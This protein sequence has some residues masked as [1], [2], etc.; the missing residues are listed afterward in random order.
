MNCL[1][2]GTAIVQPAT[3]RRRTTCSDRCRK[4]LER[5]RPGLT[6]GDLARRLE[7]E[8][9]QVDAILEPL[10]E[11]G[12]VRCVGPGR[13]TLPDQLAR[14]A[15]GPDPERT[16]PLDDHDLPMPRPGPAA[17]RPLEAVAA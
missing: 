4:A 17:R 12:L 5:G 7:V 9:R 6:R 10:V 8:P 1:H 14:F 11:H 3:G 2:C 13:W 16:I 15:Y